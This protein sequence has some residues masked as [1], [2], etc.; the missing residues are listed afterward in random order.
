MWTCLA[1]VGALTWLASMCGYDHSLCLHAA[2]ACVLW[3]LYAAMHM[4]SMKHCVCI[5]SHQL[6]SECLKLTGMHS[7]LH[8][9]LA[10][11]HLDLD[12][13][14]LRLTHTSVVRYVARCH[15]GKG[16]QKL[17]FFLGCLQ[18]VA[19]LVNCTRCLGFWT[20]IGR[21]LSM[22]RSNTARRAMHD[23]RLNFAQHTPQVRTPLRTLKQL[24]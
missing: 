4:S 9:A 6:R 19:D 20:S 17:R 7:C 13:A 12:A 18:G 8:Q 5:P 3:A 2:Q 15:G 21:H 23:G 10:P 11:M 24:Q 14:G 22:R 16:Q 1:S